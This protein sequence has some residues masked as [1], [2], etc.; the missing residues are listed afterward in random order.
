[1]GESKIEICSYA[2]NVK[3]IGG[4]GSAVS[5]LQSKYLA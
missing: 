4:A 1:M 5:D 3:R 2:G